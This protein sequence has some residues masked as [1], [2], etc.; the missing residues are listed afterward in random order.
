MT[1][2]VVFLLF[3]AQAANRQTDRQTDTH[4]PLITVP[5]YRL[6]PV[7]VIS[8][9]TNIDLLRHLFHYNVPA[10]LREL[11]CWHASQRDSPVLAC[12][13]PPGEHN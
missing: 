5:T 2:Q 13:V 7:L 4:M 6:P 12:L 9:A 8:A 3:T 10:H 11:E 1:A